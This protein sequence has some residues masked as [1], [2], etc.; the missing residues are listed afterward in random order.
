[1]ASI[2]S[3]MANVPHGASLTVTLTPDR[4]GNES[5]RS[6]MY[7]GDCN[8]IMDDNTLD[9]ALVLDNGATVIPYRR[10]ESIG[11]TVT[12]ETTITAS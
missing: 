6:G 9:A 1:M 2:Q 7:A 12:T 3:Q 4:A 5:Q 8:V 10:V 11:V